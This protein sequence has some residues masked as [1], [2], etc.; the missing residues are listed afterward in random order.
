MICRICKEDKEKEEFAK[1]LSYCKKCDNARAVEY[2]RSFLGHIVTIYNA[3]INHSKDREH[4]PPEYS[5]DEFINFI[6][7]D[8]KYILLHNEWVN[9]GFLKK[10]S[11]SIDRLD[12]YEGYSFK[13]IQ[14]TT[15]GNNNILAYERRKSGLNNKQSR[16]IFCYNFT[17]AMVS[18]YH[19]INCAAREFGLRA[20]HISECA[21]GK[22]KQVGG[23]LWKFE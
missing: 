23:Y 9:S 18:K 2:R 14:I 20:G 1:H 12:E 16:E 10:L 5:K 17:G 3:Q 6:S 7:M 13:N 4:N 22:R 8:K 19:S 11:P 21:Y 15:W